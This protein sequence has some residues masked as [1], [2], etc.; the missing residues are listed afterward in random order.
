MKTPMSY[1]AVRYWPTAA[2][3]SR[4][5]QLEAMAELYELAVLQATSSR[6]EP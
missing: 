4:C 3:K 5:L 6:A 1:V 2:L